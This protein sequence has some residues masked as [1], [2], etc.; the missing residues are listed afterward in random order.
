[1]QYGGPDESDYM[2]Y[3]AYRL[4][5]VNILQ[6]TA[7][8]LFD[9]SCGFD[10]SMFL[11]K[12]FDPA[13]PL[14][15]FI[16]GDDNY[17]APQ[18]AGLGGPLR[19]GHYSLVVTGDSWR[20]SGYFSLSVV[21]LKPF[22][23][24]AVPEP[25]TWLMLLGGLLAVGLAARRHGRRA[26][27][28]A[29][30]AGAVQQASADVV[31]VSGDTTFGPT[32]HRPSNYGGEPNSLGQDVAYRAYNISVTAEAGEF[33]FLTVCGYNCGTFLYEGSF[34]P[35]DSYRNILDGRAL[36]GTDDMGESAISVYLRRG[37]QYVLVVTGYGDYDW[38]E[39]FTTI[40]GTGGISISA[41]PEPS[42]SLMLLGGLMAI[43]VAARRRN[44]GR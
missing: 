26:L 39:Y 31:T 27:V 24:T 16:A 28:L 9:L 19:A 40:A 29:L 11:Y 17:V 33:S 44:K 14:Q 4:F 20:D 32:F 36:G 38:G 25:S 43:G 42:T 41:V 21:G 1:M 6:N 22:T 5:D 15:D 10:C 34:N 30:L 35:A 7:G 13:A 37:Q 8:I 12:S 18:T 2:G 3:T 23:I